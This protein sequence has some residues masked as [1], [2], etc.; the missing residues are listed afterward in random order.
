VNEQDKV[1]GGEADQWQMG[2]TADVVF[3]LI[4]FKFIMLI[5]HM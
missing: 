1:K 2:S 5:L 4:E 3:V